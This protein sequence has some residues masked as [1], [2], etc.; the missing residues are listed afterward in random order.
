MGFLDWARNSLLTYQHDAPLPK[1]ST[2]PLFQSIFYHSFTEG[3]REFP[4][5]NLPSHDVPPTKLYVLSWNVDS[6]AEHPEERLQALV[7]SLSSDTFPARGELDFIFLQE[8]SSNAFPALL[9]S[10]FVKNNFYITDVD[11]TSW[12]TNTFG[13]VTLVR[14]APSPSGRPALQVASVYR[15]PYHSHMG[16][17]ALCCDILIDGG[18]RM[19]AINVHLDSLNI[20]PPL[21]P[22]QLSLCAEHLR[23]AG[24]VGFV[25]GDFNAISPRDGALAE[26]VGLVDAWR[27]AHPDRD[28]SEGATWGVQVEETFPP[29]R[30]D[31]AAV[32]GLRPAS[33]TV[34]P[35]GWAG[36]TLCSDHCGLLVEMYL[37]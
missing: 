1:L 13:S 15:L 19:R 34:L 22:M 10:E 32:L 18:I 25:A 2:P 30:L 29:G 11:H 16:R 17:D 33:V 20:N 24:G 8:V 28:E 26:E 36:N 3:W 9:N 12:R 31:R 5:S 6:T 21:R 7:V 4:S 14:R 23:S 27:A 37:D 35:S